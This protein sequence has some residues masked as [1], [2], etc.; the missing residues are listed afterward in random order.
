MNPDELFDRLEAADEADWETIYASAEARLSR[1][2]VFQALQLGRPCADWLALRFDVGPPGQ[3][4]PNIEDSIRRVLSEGAGTPADAWVLAMTPGDPDAD[5]PDEVVL[6]LLINGTNAALTG[7]TGLW[8]ASWL[9]SRAALAAFLLGQPEWTWRLLDWFTLRDGS[10]HAR[11][12]RIVMLEPVRG[13]P[14]LERNAWLRSALWSYWPHLA[15]LAVP[16]LRMPEPTDENVLDVIERLRAVGASDAAGLVESFMQRMDASANRGRETDSLV[17]ELRRRVR[18]GEVEP[19]EADVLPAWFAEWATSVGREREFRLARL[20]GLLLHQ[21]GADPQLVSI[22]LLRAL[23]ASDLPVFLRGWQQPEVRRGFEP[24]AATC[25][26]LPA[27]VA[28]AFVAA[29]IPNHDAH[30]EGFSR[31]IDNRQL[32]EEAMIAAGTQSDGGL[33]HLLGVLKGAAADRNP[34]AEIRSRAGTFLEAVQCEI[35]RLPPLAEVSMVD[36]RASAERLEAPDCT[37]AMFWAVG[38]PEQPPMTRLLACLALDQRTPRDDLKYDVQQTIMQEG[39][40]QLLPLRR[41]MLE[42]LLDNPSC[43]QRA[44]LMFSLANTVRATTPDDSR[45]VALVA[46]RLRDASR[47]ARREGDAGIEVDAELALMRLEGSWSRARLDE[48]LARAPANRRGELL[49][50]RVKATEG[51]EAFDL[52]EAALAE[53]G[54]AHPSAP[55]LVAFVVQYLGST[56]E[57]DEALARVAPFLESVSQSH[58]RALLLTVAG[59]LHVERRDHERA[60]RMAREALRLYLAANSSQ[61]LDVRLDLLRIAQETSNSTLFDEQRRELSSDEVRLSSEQRRRLL[62]FEINHAVGHGELDQ[63]SSLM[64]QAIAIAPDEGSAM[65]LRLRRL[66]MLIQHG[67][68][69]QGAEQLLMQGLAIDET[70][71]QAATIACDHGMQFSAALLEQVL[72]V[73]RTLDEPI[74]EARLLYL[75]KRGDEADA[76]LRQRLEQLDEP[77]ARFGLIHQHLIIAIGLSRSEEEI[78]AL[79][80]E[81]EQGLEQFEHPSGRLDLAESLR[82]TANGDSDRLWRAWRHLVRAMVSLA[83]KSRQHA[84]GRALET[85]A[86]LAVAQLCQPPDRLLEVSEW[87]CCEADPSDEREQVRLHVATVLLASGRLIRE[88]ALAAAG[89][90]VLAVQEELGETSDLIRLANRLELIAAWAEDRPA[91]LRRTRLSDMPPGPFD[92]VPPWLEVAVRGGRSAAEDFDDSLIWRALHCRSDVADA[93]VAAVVRGWSHFSAGSKRAASELCL[94]AIGQFGAIDPDNWSLT[95]RALAEVG[96]PELAGLMAE[97]SRKQGR[98]QASTPESNADPVELYRSAVYCIE[99]VQQAIAS[100]EERDGDLLARGISQLEAARDRALESDNPGVAFC[101]WISLGN[102]LKLAARPDLDEAIRC[103]REAQALSEHAGHADDAGRLEKVWADALWMLGGPEDLREAHSRIL[104]AIRLRMGTVRAEA[105][106]SAS[107]IAA[108]HPDWDESERL[109]RCVAHLLSAAEIEPRVIRQPD[110]LRYLV[111]QIT[112]W[113]VSQPDAPGPREAVERFEALFPDQTEALTRLRGDFG[114]GPDVQRLA[115]T[116]GWTDDPDWAIAQRIRGQLLSASESDAGLRM[117]PGMRPFANQIAEL[118]AQ[119]RLRGDAA[120]VRTAIA[121][122]QADEDNEAGRW[123]A[124][125]LL[126]AELVR[127]GSGRVED[128]ETAHRRAEAACSSVA[129]PGPR[130]M[131]LDTL[132]GVWC[133]DD[134]LDATLRDFDR[135][136]RLSGEAMQL[137]GGPQAAVLDILERHARSLLYTQTGARSDNLAR[138]IELYR[139]LADRARADGFV[140]LA[141]NALHCQSVAMRQQGEGDRVARLRQALAVEERAVALASSPLQRARLQS[142]LAWARTELA[143]ILRGADQREELERA[144]AEFDEVE[145]GQLNVS[146]R[147]GWRLNRTSCAA[148]IARLRD[149]HAAEAQVWAELSASN[150]FTTWPEERRSVA[151][152]NHGAALMARDPSRSVDEFNEGLRIAEAALAI[153]LAGSSDQYRWQTSFELARQVAL[154]LAGRDD[155]VE[156]DDLRWFLE[157]EAHEQVRAWLRIAIEAARN[158]GCGDELANA[159]F[160]M[161]RMACLQSSSTAIV[162]WADEAWDALR[163]ALPTLLFDRPT[164]AQEQGLAKLIALRLADALSR[165][166]V[167]G[168]RQGLRYAMGGDRA[169]LV[170]RW[171]ARAQASDRRTFAGRVDRPTGVA[172]STWLEWRDAVA[173]RTSDRLPALYREIARDCPRFLTDDIS[174]GPTLRWLRARPGSVGLA[175]VAADHGQPVLALS[176]TATDGGHDVT[177]VGLQPP[178]RNEELLDA[179]LGANAKRPSAVLWNPD[180]RFLAVHPSR[181]FGSTPVAMTT[182]IALPASANPRPRRRST[183]IALADPESGY[184]SLEGAGQRVVN[185]LAATATALGPVTR[186]G[187]RIGHSELLGTAGAHDLLVVVAHADDIDGE[188]NLI[189]VDKDGRPA[190]LPASNL[191]I[192]GPDAFHGACVLLLSCTAGKVE[193]RDG[194]LA[195]IAGALIGAGAR[196]VVAPMTPI[197]LT[198]ARDAAIMVI[199]GLLTGREPREVVVGCRDETEALVVWLG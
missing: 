21:H 116:F 97:V 26:H 186:I 34:D 78:E 10:R 146:Q 49:Y 9:G 174:L 99:A 2:G 63:A 162:Q 181:M 194:S 158:L 23:R 18:D 192:Q 161:A 59:R 38:I 7:A 84:H 81:L 164:L 92:I 27:D 179:V 82:R 108:A 73:A 87:L 72:P 93:I 129:A 128:V 112:A 195:G 137:L 50:A 109:A 41:E 4:L 39:A 58:D 13:R 45:S 117:L 103:Y 52:A 15:I 188:A 89:Q 102:A 5:V 29:F 11:F 94:R 96:R 16:A 47:Q 160:C 19:P 182:A 76:S 120:G 74:L 91:V 57:F 172:T 65:D 154:V 167:Q 138:S 133:V 141:S 178:A 32:I 64:G 83:P 17:V 171:I 126:E 155:A 114:I 30:A 106:F 80:D 33:A 66:A 124:I 199:E 189:L 101:A 183:L 61:A 90:L 140:D 127:L 75:L 24:L 184:D 111:R 142:N 130:A 119:Q 51:P 153:R 135:A 88:D 100:G 55:D 134:D 54:E 185:D 156:A 170:L 118:Q 67:Q 173:R 149:G 6:A 110:V 145:L 3:P 69:P 143:L 79:M 95:E 150:E 28:D 113:R 86:D 1:E 77:A 131:L 176:L 20:A 104:N 168:R 196:L 198:A 62:G 8:F 136:A 46:A 98:A 122:L 166:G 43:P 123:V 159:A 191:A 148:G 70:C 139:V 60:E 180:G 37:D 35:E 48:L 151:M 12:E 14:D 197:A 56:G 71:R 121:G 31:S 44:Q 85:I 187:P 115:E 177:V 165:E 40:F 144:L 25:A 22:C 152:H 68:S 105:H 163:E 169:N 190:P 147:A 193:R 42:A 107:R 36:L 175:V 157:S 53:I 132:A 125:T